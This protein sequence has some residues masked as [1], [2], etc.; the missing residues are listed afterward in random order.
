MRTALIG[1]LLSLGATAAE[2]TLVGSSGKIAA[3]THEPNH[4]W[5]LN[6]R[7]CLAPPVAKE[8]TA[9]AQPKPLECGWI[10]MTT[11]L[12]AAVKFSETPDNLEKGRAVV[13]PTEPAPKNALTLAEGARRE[14][15]LF[16][17]E[18]MFPFYRFLL[19]GSDKELST[20]LL[21]N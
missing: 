21:G 6:E 18:E 9:P 1:I 2:V 4:P 14:A 11:T 19:T 7:A 8:G 10:I 5:D 13:V 16:H 12:G 17:W 20:N 15:E 3:I